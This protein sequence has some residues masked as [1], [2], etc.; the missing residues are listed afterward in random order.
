MNDQNAINEREWENRSNWTA[1]SIYRSSRDSRLFVPKPPM[2][3]GPLKQ[4]GVTLNFGHPS[5]FWVL[6]G[7]LSVPLGFLL[8]FVL[9]QLSE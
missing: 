4:T 9:Y 7:L 3:W 5:S 6:L 1:R 2:R 8:L